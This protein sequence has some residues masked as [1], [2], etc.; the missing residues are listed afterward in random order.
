[1]TER[2]LDDADDE[3][4]QPGPGSDAGVAHQDVV[5]AGQAEPAGDS[6]DD[7]PMPGAGEVFRSGS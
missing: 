5:E 7:T 1:M 6:E 2:A 3:L 4:D